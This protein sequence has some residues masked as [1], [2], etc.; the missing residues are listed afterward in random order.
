VERDVPVDL[1]AD[2]R[3]E[4]SLH[5]PD[6]T[7]AKRVAAAINA[8]VPNSACAEASDP[9]TIAV[10]LPDAG[11]NAAMSLLERIETL[12][13]DVDR[14]ARI[15]VNERTGTV[16]VGQDVRIAPVAI[17]HGTLQ[18]EI[19]TD[20]GVSQPTPFSEGQTVIVPDSQIVA[21]EGKAGSLAVLQ[22]GVTLGDLVGALN[23]LGVTPQDLIAILSAIQ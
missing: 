4:I 18:I 2:G 10:R 8:R 23:A 5:E 6:I 21:Q 14:P 19:K 15:V 9:K 1:G 3:M 20:Y 12:H 22:A 7:T 17:A 13:V 11:P 16:I